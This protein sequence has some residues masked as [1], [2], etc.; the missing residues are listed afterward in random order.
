MIEH[1]IPDAV[2]AMPLDR[3]LRRAWPMVPGRVLRDLYKKKDVRVNGVKSDGQATVRGGDALTLYAEPHWFEPVADILWT[4]EKLV[5]AVKPMGLPVDVD[6]DD[7]GADT[8]LTRLRRRWPG[9]RLC[10]R[11]DAQTGGIVL[12][13]ADDTVLEQALEA[14]RSHG[15]QKEYRALAFNRFERPEGTMTHPARGPSKRATGR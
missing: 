6:R 2:P 5:V 14:F 8:L 15:L 10:H 13:A 7:I 1:R 3:D 9:A 4:D 11:L 12:A